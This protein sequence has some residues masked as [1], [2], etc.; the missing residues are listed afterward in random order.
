[1]S[2]TSD[3]TRNNVRAGVFVTVGIVLT[4]AVIGVLT[5]VWTYFEPTH[6]YRVRFSVDDGVQ[7]IKPGSE[8][9]VGGL[10]M[11]RVT[12]IEPIHATEGG[13]LE[14][15]DVRIRLRRTVAIHEDA[16]AVRVA[17]LL[18]S[19]SAI[20][21]ASTGTAAGA[22]VP[23]GGTLDAT[24]AGGM[25][26][27]FIGPEVAADIAST[28]DNVEAFSTFLRDVREEYADRIVPILDSAQAA[29]TNVQGLT[30][31]AV[32]DYARWVAAVDRAIQRG[33]DAMDAANDVL[34]AGRGTVDQ[35]DAAVADARAIITDA[36][37]PVRNTL[38]HAEAIGAD[39]RQLVAT[40]RD[41]TVPRAHALLDRAHEGVDTFA[42]VAS[43][44]DA[45][46]QRTTP[47]LRDIVT[48][49]RHTA[50]QI[51]FAS[52]ELRRSPWK[53]LYRAT[54]DEIQHELLY[55]AAR[56]FAVAVTDLRDTS[57]S[58]QNILD[59]H[60]DRLTDPD[61][62]RQIEQHLRERLDNYTK[63]QEALLNMLALDE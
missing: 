41:E 12:G 13:G 48:D 24:R 19:M 5:E 49:A 28:L 61:S 55:E 57:L 39:A 4:M 60:G 51:K 15:I 22:T 62:M 63:A 17:P 9:R 6:P 38:D 52:N 46:F 11:G 47:G 29:T 3:R 16:V 26:D 14:A 20:N 30:D 58:M 33:N 27:D 53:L 18:G 23:P 44:I 59:A 25:L 2:T 32:D 8:V 56:T 10:P 34:A 42:T 35:V 43:R 31:R 45:E 54:P 7:G 40:F 21:F 50:Q 37:E 36:R 1:M